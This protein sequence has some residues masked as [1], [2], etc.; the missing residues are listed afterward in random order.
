MQTFAQKISHILFLAVAIVLLSVACQ[1]PQ[2]RVVAPPNNPPANAPA[3]QKQPQ[4]V[5]PQPRTQPQQQTRQP[6]IDAVIGPDGRVY[7]DIVFYKGQNGKSALELLKAKYPGKIETTK[8]SYGEFVNVI[9]GIKPD[10]QHFW[11]FY[12]NDKLSNVGAGSYITED[13]D[14]ISW[15]LEEI[16][17]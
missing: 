4:Q 7:G 12:V 3:S 15:K 9:D 6:F 11:A 14:T 13:S 2:L 10:N 16:K 17:N 5:Q 8:S 1:R